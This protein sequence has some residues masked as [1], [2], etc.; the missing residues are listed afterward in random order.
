MRRLV[1]ASGLVVALASPAYAI[2]W[3]PLSFDDNTQ[4]TYQACKAS[5]E[6]QKQIKELTYQLEQQNE[7]IRRN[8]VLQM[9]QNDYLY[10]K[11]Y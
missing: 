4:N 6:Q 2:C 11:R 8:N 3:V 10:S 9:E 7:Q 5:E 1:I